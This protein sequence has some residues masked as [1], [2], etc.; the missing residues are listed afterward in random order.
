L[1]QHLHNGRL[2]DRNRAMVALASR[3]KI[4]SRTICTF[5]GVGKAFVRKYRNMFDSKGAEFVFAPQTKS[6]RKIDN[7]D[8]W[9]NVFSL[10]HEPPNNHG[11]NRTSWTMA[12]LRRVLK[13]DGTHVGT[14]LLAKM[15]KAAGY[16][17][18]K[19]KIVLTSNDPTYKEKLARIRHILSSLQADEAFF[20]IDEYGPFAIK[21]KP[22][23][24]L[25]ALG[26]QPTVPQWQKSRGCLIMMAAL[27]LSGNQVTHFY[28]PKKNTSEMIRMMDVLINRYSDRRKLYLSWDAASWHISKQLFARIDAYNSAV[29]DEGGPLIET[30]PLPAGAQFLNVVESVFSGMARA[31]IHNSDYKSMD[32]A[33]AAIDR[34]FEDRN[35]NFQ[36]HPR[37]AGKKIW[38]GEREPSAFSEANNCKDPRY[39]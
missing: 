36:Q 12:L 32:A 37:R 34:Y 3:R 38:G 2:L 21:A 11:I 25:S 18:R 17:W 35:D 1:L 7:E 6:N 13:E 19:A 28:S 27:E 33:K 31:I 24:T 39:R 30:A 14:A 20:S 16:K 26:V 4:P 23:R 15:I 29:P 22:G 5:L 8:L 9:R 10:L